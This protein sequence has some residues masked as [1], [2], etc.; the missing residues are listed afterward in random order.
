MSRSTLKNPRIALVYDH[1]TTAFGGAEVVLD[2]LHQ[3]YP[4]APLFTTVADVQ[5]A[6]WAR[7][8]KI[9]TTFLQKLPS[10][11]ARR[12]Q[13]HALIAPIAIE[14]LDVSTFDI[15]ISV[16]AGAAKGIITRPD[17]LHICYLLTPTRYLYDDA[18]FVSHS[19]LRLPVV[20]WLATQCF[21][22]LR[23]WDMAAAHRPDRLIVISKLVGRRT[24]QTYGCKPDLVLYPPFRPDPPDTNQSLTTQNSQPAQNSRS[25]PASQG[26]KQ[27]QF[28]EETQP[29]DLIISRLVWYKRVELAVAT[30]LSAQTR[31]VIVGDGALFHTL[32]AQADSKGLSKHSTE[33]VRSFIARAQK[34]DAIILFCGSVS[35]EETALLKQN[36]RSLLMLGIEDF[37]MTALEALAHGKPVVID[38][39]S[40]VAELLQ[41][42]KHGF[43]LQNPDE[44]SLHQAFTALQ[45]HHFSPALLKRTALRYSD[46]VFR[47]SF[48]ST[49]QRMWQEKE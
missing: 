32:V 42:Q 8:W 25:T 24:E 16:T 14:S 36:C 35:D 47:Q 31:L 3:L 37:G 1:V 5:R 45:T 4:S 49:V 19:W 43:L 12:H 23:W 17:Q 38:Q 9:H 44:A 40:G 28:P 29:F 48:A 46:S 18:V 26:T 10:F 6:P 34:T 2:Q 27:D 39:S 22:Y 21:R 13:W 7:G 11:L 20:R 30:A 33:T 41:D 15:I